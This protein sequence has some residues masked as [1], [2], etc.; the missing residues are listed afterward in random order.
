MGTSFIISITLIKKNEGQ[1]IVIKYL[2]CTFLDQLC[3]QPLDHFPG[4]LVFTKLVFDPDLEFFYF[5]FNHPQ[6]LT[7]L[8]QKFNLKAISR[9]GKGSNDEEGGGPL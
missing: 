3:L 1:A 4:K 8:Y 2:F 7:Y 6:K 9:H 5:C